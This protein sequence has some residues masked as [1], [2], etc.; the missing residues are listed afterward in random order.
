MRSNS[1]SPPPPVFTGR[2]AEH[3]WLKTISEADAFT[4][5]VLDEIAPWLG[6]RVL[7]VGCGTGTYT[8]AIADGCRQVVAVDMDEA[9]IEATL[10]RVGSRSGVTVVCGDAT[11]VEALMPDGQLFDTV[12]MLD[13]LEHIEDD[14]DIL[15]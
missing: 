15:A 4:R 8:A 13:V 6:T 10:R 12:I 2:A 1:E 7:E 14:V 5:W 11:L 9:H 3:F